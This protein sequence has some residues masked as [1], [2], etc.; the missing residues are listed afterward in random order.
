MVRYKLLKE[1]NITPLVASG[2]ISINIATWI[3][4]YEF[5][6]NQLNTNQKVIAIQYSSEYYKISIQ[7]IYK[8]INF[9]EN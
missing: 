4:I 3:T 8:I 6:L 2:I 1:T 7:T 5:Y 9:M